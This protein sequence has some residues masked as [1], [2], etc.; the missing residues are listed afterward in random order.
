MVQWDSVWRWHKVAGSLM[1][2]VLARN[3]ALFSFSFFPSE[4][5][6]SLN[7]MDLELEG[8][9]GQKKPPR[10]E[11][12]KSLIANASILFLFWFC[13]ARK[14]GY[15][16]WYGD[17]FHS[18]DLVLESTLQFL[19]IFPF[20]YRDFLPWS[21]VYH[22]YFLDN[23]YIVLNFSY[24]KLQWLGSKKSLN[25]WMQMILLSLEPA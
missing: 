25:L 24:T 2:Q 17:R 23:N 4:L 15:F 14:W 20:H 19:F 6:K 8:G 5:C 12:K 10:K 9:A 22:T 7:P 11:R 1:L 21:E 13:K 18:N 16:I 3:K